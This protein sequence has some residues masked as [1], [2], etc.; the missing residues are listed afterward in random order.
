MI[1]STSYTDRVKFINDNSSINGQN[2]S[3]SNFSGMLLKDYYYIYYKSFD[4]IL[5]K[6]KFRNRKNEDYYNITKEIHEYIMKILK[7]KPSDYFMK[8]FSEIEIFKEI[9][10]SEVP[11]LSDL[12][13]CNYNIIDMIIKVFDL[14]IF[15]KYEDK[16]ISFNPWYDFN[17][18]FNRLLQEFAEL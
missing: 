16:I 15:Q 13:L 5:L 10:R 12:N 17:W 11:R 6:Y 8:Q 1:V 14:D 18:L 9:L 4:I 7:N 2:L 3:C